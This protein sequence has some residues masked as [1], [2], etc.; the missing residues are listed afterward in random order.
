[1]LVDKMEGWCDVLALCFS[2]KISISYCVKMLKNMSKTNAATWSQ[3]YAQYFSNL[4][5]SYFF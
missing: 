1:M 3:I 5:Q 2:Q 4:L